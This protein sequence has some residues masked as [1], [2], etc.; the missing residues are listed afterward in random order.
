MQL[1]FEFNRF[2]KLK[3]I[4]DKRG[5]LKESISTLEN[6]AGL[7]KRIMEGSKEVSAAGATI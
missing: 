1:Y 7:I 2:R 4:D 6:K 5:Q 3:E